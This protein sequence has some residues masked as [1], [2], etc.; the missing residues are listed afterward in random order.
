MQVEEMG[1]YLNYFYNV[2]GKLYKILGY[3]K[4]GEDFRLRDSTSLEY[5]FSNE[6]WDRYF[7][8]I[9]F[10]GY[11]ESSSE[12]EFDSIGNTLIRNSYSWSRFFKI[13]E[14]T[15]DDKLNPEINIMTNPIFQG[16]NN[17]I[18][19]KQYFVD[20][21]GI[22]SLWDSVE[23]TLIYNSCNYPIKSGE[24]FTYEYQCE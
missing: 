17:Y 7:K 11:S 1:S 10:D 14:F 21:E 15:Y 9:Y 18:T 13:E 2:N 16:K 5:S 19:R 4:F 22:V 24:L 8:K 12:I 20:E 6:Y 3:R 23:R